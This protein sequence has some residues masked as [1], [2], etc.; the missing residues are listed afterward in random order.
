MSNC[1]ECDVELV[2]GI[3]WWPSC[4]AKGDYRCIECG[5]AY[6]RQYRRDHLEEAAARARRYYRVHPERVAA[7]VRQW[8]QDNR[9][10]VREKDQRRRAR[11]AGVVLS[12]VNEQPIYELYDY[13][14]VYCGSKEDLTLDHVVSLASGGPHSEGNLVVACRRCNSSKQ[15]K[16]LEDWLQTWPA[17]RHPLNG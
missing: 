17:L 4:A 16:P 8:R 6:N 10:K 12:E 1:R 5:R 9:D 3:N 7:R 13:T 14:C 2:A 15:D 11:K